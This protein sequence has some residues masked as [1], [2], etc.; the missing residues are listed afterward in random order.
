MDSGIQSFRCAGENYGTF[1]S[2]F[3]A[4]PMTRE[5]TTDLEP[6]FSQWKSLPL[7]NGLSFTVTFKYLL[8][9]GTIGWGLW[10]SQG[11]PDRGK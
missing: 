5:L 11:D 2:H 9:S 4:S 7:R 3:L 6:G 8:M 10:I 1:Q